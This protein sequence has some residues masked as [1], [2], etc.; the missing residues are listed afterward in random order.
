MC[1]LKNKKEFMKDYTNNNLEPDPSKNENSDKN[2]KPIKSI[3]IIRFAIYESALMLIGFAALIY[4][5]IFGLKQEFPEIIPVILLIIS[6][7]LIIYNKKII[8]FLIKLEK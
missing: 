8:S 5:D 3:F 7:P 1:N 6:L 4:F 2:S